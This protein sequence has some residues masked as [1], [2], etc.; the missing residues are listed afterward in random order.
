[1]VQYYY[2]Y[3]LLFL[4][5]L[6]DLLGLILVWTTWTLLFI[7]SMIIFNVA[8]TSFKGVFFAQQGV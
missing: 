3:P 8:M 4:S 7:Y 6:K 1:M 5:F 2:S